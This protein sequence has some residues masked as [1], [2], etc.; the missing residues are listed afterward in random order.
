[1]QKCFQSYVLNLG[2]FFIVLPS[3]KQW[4]NPLKRVYKKCIYKSNRIE[5]CQTWG[6]ILEGQ[7]QT[8]C[9]YMFSPLLTACVQIWYCRRGLFQRSFE[10][11]TFLWQFKWCKLDLMETRSVPGS[12]DLGS[13]TR[14]TFITCCNKTIIL[15]NLSSFLS[16]NRLSAC[17]HV[18]SCGSGRYQYFIIQSLSHFQCV[19]VMNF[20][21][22]PFSSGFQ[23]RLWF[24]LSKVKALM[25]FW[26]RSNSSCHI[27]Y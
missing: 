26:F 16:E 3:L 12:L 9:S 19:P 11:F 6:E 17:G 14:F 20:M 15:H 10:Q 18:K 7:A 22:M 21:K 24:V 4:N 23:G 27:K 13:G 1:M 25:C 5:L 2:F 8:P